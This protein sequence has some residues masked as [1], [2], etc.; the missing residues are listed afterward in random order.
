[1]VVTLALIYPATTIAFSA[2]LTVLIPKDDS[3][4]RPRRSWYCQ[5]Q[6]HAIG[7]PG[8]DVA[9]VGGFPRRQLSGRIPTSPSE[10]RW[11][12]PIGGF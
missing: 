6:K 5:G 9:A 10:K 8:F 11:N 12:G 4:T 3:P 2:P 1:V 7:V